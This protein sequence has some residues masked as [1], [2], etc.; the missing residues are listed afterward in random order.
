MTKNE[1]T[2]L[3]AW[4]FS[5]YAEY[6][7]SHALFYSELT[8]FDVYLLHTVKDKSLVEDT[9]A[10]LNKSVQEIWEHQSKKVKTIVKISN[11]S[12]GLKEAAQEL[13]SLMIFGGLLGF[14]GL[15]RFIGHYVKNAITGSIIPS[16]VVQQAK[17]KTDQLTL[18]CPI[19][20]S[21]QSKTNLVWVQEL[22]KTCNPKI[23]LVYPDCNYSTRN[24]LASSNLNFSRNYLKRFNIQ[25]EEEKLSCLN[26]KVNM[27]N[28]AENKHADLILNATKKESRFN[29][30]FFKSENYS[31]MANDKQIPVMS[32]KPQ[33]GLWKYGKFY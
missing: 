17:Q 21:R 28:F 18:I 8:G 9:Q 30:F 22:A 32:I 4:D 25:F 24:Q 11:M 7:L 12:D 13:N 6:A 10:A 19:D 5:Q 3:V 15:Q 23:Y 2:I 31:L 27:L 26:F 14:K 33:E 1:K 16:V 20:H 29:N